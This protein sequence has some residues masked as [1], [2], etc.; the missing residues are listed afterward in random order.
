MAEKKQHQQERAKPG[1]A[2][3]EKKTSKEHE[4]KKQK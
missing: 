1:Y 2:N 3:P 4:K